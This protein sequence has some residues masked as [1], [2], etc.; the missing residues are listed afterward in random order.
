MNDLPFSYDQ[1]FQLEDV[2]L[3]LY[4]E[5]KQYEQPEQM[6]GGVETW[7]TSFYEV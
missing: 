2:L 1:N 6:F 5:N 3:D 7:P 4:C